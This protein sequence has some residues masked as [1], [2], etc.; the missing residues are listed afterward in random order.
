ML[1][2][3]ISIALLIALPCSVSGERAG[4][5]FYS[6]NA[7]QIWDRVSGSPVSV[8]VRS[9]DHRSWVVARYF[10]DSAKN[11]D[12][13]VDLDVSGAI[14]TLHV[15]LGPGVA[16]ELLWAP[17]SEAFFVTTS[18]QGANGSYH[19][20]VVGSFDEKLQSR[21][22]ADLIYPVFG[23]PF[24]CSSPESPN[25]AGI[26]W[27]SKSH[28]LWVSAEVVSHSNCDSFGTFKAYEVD[29]A[30]MEVVQVMGQLDA[31]RALH[32]M[33]GPELRHAPDNCIRN[34][35]YCYVSTNHPELRPQR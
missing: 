11:V 19:L 9:P 2:V 33:L 27:S 10:D 25:I 29:P 17:D 20:L 15:N 18:D 4:K 31:K 12:E 32:P 7:F 5:G 14:G 16:S 34:P 13:H 1:R 8:V 21:E 28:K 26:A 22:I 23:H 3:W 30:R 35:R 6:R 24:R